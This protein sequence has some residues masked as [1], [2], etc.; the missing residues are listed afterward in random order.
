MWRVPLSRRIGTDTRCR[1]GHKRKQH[2]VVKFG[3]CFECGCKAFGVEYPDAPPNG[4]AGVPWLDG[5]VF[6]AAMYAYR[7]APSSDPAEVNRAFEEVKSMIRHNMRQALLGADPRRRAT[8]TE[9]RS[10]E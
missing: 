4:Q 6:Y 1:C 9:N 3:V 7:Y 8:E 10:S 5:D 2:G